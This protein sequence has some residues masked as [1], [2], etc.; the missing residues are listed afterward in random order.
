MNLR[1]VTQVTAVL[2][3][4]EALTSA[5]ADALEGLTRDQFG[6]SPAPHAISTVAERSALL[7]RVNS[8]YQDLVGQ[9][10]D[11]LLGSELVGPIAID[12]GAREWR[13]HRLETE[14]SYVSEPAI[15]HH[16][17]GR[18]VEVLISARRMRVNGEVMDIESFTDVTSLVAQHRRQ[19]D[20]VEA[21]AYRDPVT[22]LLNR[23][24]FEAQLS[25][26]VAANGLFGFAVAVI[27]MKGFNHTADTYG[28]VVSEALLREYAARL[29]R[30]IVGKSFIARIGEDEFAMMIRGCNLP[31]AAMEQQLFSILCE[32]F[33]PVNVGRMEFAI[34]A[35]LGIAHADEAF[36]SAKLLLS[37]ADDR[38]SAAKSTGQHV[39]MVGR[40]FA[41]GV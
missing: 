38:T 19:M 12:D 3:C 14:G 17:S 23:A 2:D 18:P 29:Q 22:G 40:T 32:V 1:P 20:A 28:R 13:M 5:C 7:L 30:P 16:A 21:H 9:P 6:L 25:Q 35:A 33:A 24:G 27:E 36:A 15:I 37:L 8:A 31:V 11:R 26:H 10:M 39:V 4:A 34:G 41:M